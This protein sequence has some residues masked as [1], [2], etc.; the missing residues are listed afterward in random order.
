LAFV[1]LTIPPLIPTVV[2]AYANEYHK[3]KYFKDVK[4]DKIAALE[5]KVPSKVLTYM[6]PCKLLKCA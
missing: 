4:Y 6:N 3:T 2:D 1:Y 5:A